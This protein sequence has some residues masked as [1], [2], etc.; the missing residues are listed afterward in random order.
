MSEGHV[1]QCILFNQP[2]Y[3]P[4]APFE[5]SESSSGAVG[6][7]HVKLVPGASE[8]LRSKLCPGV[9]GVDL[10]AAVPGV[11]EELRSKSHPG[12]VGIG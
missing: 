5:R 4:A 10:R 9:V 11:S 7:D 12:I 3:L 8:E 2:E 6:V 1:R